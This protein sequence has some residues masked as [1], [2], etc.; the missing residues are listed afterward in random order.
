MICN[1]ALKDY[2]RVKNFPA[3]EKETINELTSIEQELQQK[4]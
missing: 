2:T 1:K 4:T 3:F